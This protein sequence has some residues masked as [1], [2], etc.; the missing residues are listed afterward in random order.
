MKNYIRLGAVLLIFSAVA[1]LV[2]ALINGQTA[3][4]IAEMEFQKTTGAFTEIFGDEADAIEP[5]DEAVKMAIIE[6]YPNITDI[7]VVT[8]GGEVVGHGI[9]FTANGYGG[10]MSNAIALRVDK[11]IAGF[12]NIQHA[13]TPGIGAQIEEPAYYELF[14]NKSFADGQVN[15]AVGAP[16]ENDVPLISGATVSTA[17]ILDSLNMLLPAYDEIL[18]G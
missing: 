17:G 6:K 18:Q 7:F 2:L 3:P 11:T 15:G 5:M 13:E 16:G 9:T 10:G 1:G 12:R 14:Q 8:K 4:I